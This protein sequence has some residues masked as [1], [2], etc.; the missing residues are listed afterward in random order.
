MYVRRRPTR[1]FVLA[2]ALAATVLTGLAILVIFTNWKFDRELAV[3]PKPPAPPP[4]IAPAKVTAKQF[5]AL[6]HST[7]WTTVGKARPD[8]QPFAFSD[9]LVVHPRKATVVYAEPGG[10][11]IAVLPA[12]QLDNPTWLP[13]VET[14]PGWMRVLLP[15][16]PNRSTGWIHAADGQIKQSRSPYQVRIDLSDRRMAIL[17]D[18]RETGSWKV[19]IGTRQTPTP[20]GR[21]FLLASLA[22][23]GVDYSPVILPLGSHSEKLRTYDG[24]PG[25]IGLHGWP[26]SGVFGEAISHGC[27]R[28]PKPALDAATHLPLG[29]MILITE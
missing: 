17:K 13:V 1:T 3:P 26:D 16:R 8:P 23:S 14:R 18:G 29:T 9:G 20:V 6:P 5:A 12:E 4:P 25:T 19:G 24:G 2:A 10:P 22:P 28:L 7:T 11:A 21:T 15:S 27:V